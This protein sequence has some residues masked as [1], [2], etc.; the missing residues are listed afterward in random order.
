MENLQPIQIIG[1]QRSGSN[2][3]RLMLN[4]FDEI[5][6]PHPPHILKQFMPLLPIYGNLDHSENMNRLIDDVCSL[7]EYNPVSWTGVAFDRDEVRS[8]CKSRSLIEIFRVVYNL[9]AKQDRAYFWVCKSMGNMHFSDQLESAGIKPLYIHLYR[10]G[11]DVAC[12]FKNAIVGEKHIYH[13]ANQWN[14]NQEACFKLHDKIGSDRFL[15]VSYEDLIHFPEREMKRVSSFL[16]VNFD[17]TVFDYYKSKESINTATV[18]KMWE[19]VSRP[20]L[21]H[22]TMK[23]KTGLTEIELDI[24]ENQAGEILKKLGYTLDAPDRARIHFSKDQIE[25][26][27]KENQFLKEKAR[28]TADPKGMKLRARQERLI[29]EI[30][31]QVLVD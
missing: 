15:M 28:K 7:I 21:K 25:A 8:Q 16:H 24:F 22:N 31:A 12:S 11:R 3:L 5:S 26:F 6:A 4:Q 10:D 9:K 20:I 30:K 29:G 1:T 17:S 2:L 23:Y 19:N 13:L 27:D 14:E 18:G